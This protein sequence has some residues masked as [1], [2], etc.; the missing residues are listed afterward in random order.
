[1]L[2][3]SLVTARHALVLE[4]TLE[5]GGP[6][7]DVAISAARGKVLAVFGVIGA[8]DGIAVALELR[9]NLAIG[10]LVDL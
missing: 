7:N 10:R 9:N 6:D 8:V 5:L 2:L 1:M 3:L 4:K